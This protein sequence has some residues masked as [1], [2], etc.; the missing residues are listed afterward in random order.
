[1]Y[2][3]WNIKKTYKAVRY[4]YIYLS[5]PPIFNK[6]TTSLDM[7][8]VTPPKKKKKEMYLRIY[9]DSEIIVKIMITRNLIFRLHIT[10]TLLLIG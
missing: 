9:Y 7:H 5:T 10:V 2:V 1:M 6:A 3:A 8:N 4:I